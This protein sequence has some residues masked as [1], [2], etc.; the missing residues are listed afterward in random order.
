MPNAK[1]T[2]KVL[3][4]QGS[5]MPG[6]LVTLTFMDPE[7]RNG[8][9]VEGTTNAEGI[10]SGEGQ[11]DGVMG[12]MV[13]KEG[14]YR[15][16]FSFKQF[17]GL[18]NGRWEPWNATYTTNLRPILKPIAMY[19]KRVQADLP[20]LDQPCG[21]DL[22]KGDWVAP[23]GKGVESDFIFK[24]HREFKTRND[25]DVRV[26]MTFTNPQDGLIKAE[27]PAIGQYSTFKWEREA[28]LA[29]YTQMIHLQNAV[30]SETV[31]HSFKRT[32]AF[33]FRVKTI[34]QNGHIIASNY[35]KISGGL[36]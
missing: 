22:E 18:S 20:A 21:Y 26:E 3:D 11:T 4:E 8:I 27:L 5:P 19:A 29:G 34:E 32:D 13:N 15:G 9:P 16:G 36:L 2:I 14:F 6:A 7:S 23:Y 24:G 30:T 1:L 28:P 12:G 25:F 31:I 17:S 35:G 33:F 10:F